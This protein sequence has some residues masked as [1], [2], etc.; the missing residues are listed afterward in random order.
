MY[1]TTNSPDFTPK[2][3][4]VNWHFWEPCNMRCAFCFAKFQDVKREMN[5]PKGHLPE[6]DCLFV[7][8]RLAKAG[9]EK[10]K[11]NSVILKNRNDDEILDLVG[12]ASA[13]GMDI[14]FIEEMPLGVIGDHDREEAYYSSDEIR[15]DLEQ[16]YSLLPSDCCSAA[17]RFCL[18][19]RELN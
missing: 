12:F 16:R 14:S 3:P 10:I 2:V 13:R 19:L 8:N 9:F 7:V 4:S 1:P 6:E 17:A 15:A 11:I 18:R 5:L